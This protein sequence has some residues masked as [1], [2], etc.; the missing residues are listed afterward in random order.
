M[1]AAAIPL[2]AAAMIMGLCAVVN[3]YWTDRWGASYADEQIRDYAARL[4][5]VPLSFGDWEGTDVPESDEGKMQLKAAHIAK[6]VQR[7]YTNKTTGETVS[8]FLATG[9]QRHLAIHTPN[10]CFVAAGYAMAA[11]PN[12]LLVDIGENAAGEPEQVAEFL[13]ANFRKDET[14]GSNYLRVLW[15][16]NAGAGW[17]APKNA[18]WTFAWEKALYK[19]YVMGPVRE[20][21]DDLKNDPRVK[22]IQEFLPEVDKVLA[23][24]AGATDSEA[25]QTAGSPAGAS[26]GEVRS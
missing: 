11:N 15:S 12:Q 21:G 8:I 17:L 22:F 19:L 23:V 14:A 26:S 20:I 10:A 18:K 24:P 16:W 13:Y 7:E 1:K 5:G 9:P 4:E 2:A 6:A 25:P 3:G